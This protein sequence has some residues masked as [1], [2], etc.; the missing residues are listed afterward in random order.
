[1]PRHTINLNISASFFW[2]GILI[3]GKYCSETFQFFLLFTAGFLL[4]IYYK[5]TKLAGEAFEKRSVNI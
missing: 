3:F 1:M 5:L 4:E 2:G